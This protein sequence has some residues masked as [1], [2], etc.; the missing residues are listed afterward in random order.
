[1]T[2]E[3]FKA[4]LREVAGKDTSADPDG[5]TPQNPLWG[6]CAIASLLA[7]DYFGGT[8]LRGSLEGV[9]KYAHLKSHFWNDLPDGEVDFTAEQYPNLKFSD[10]SKE[11]RERDRVLRRPENEQR[12]ELLKARLEKA[13]QTG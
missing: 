12:Y 11:A 5:W 2:H 1:M 7:Q 4:T 6:H 13:T 9:E 8:L 10:L 3:V